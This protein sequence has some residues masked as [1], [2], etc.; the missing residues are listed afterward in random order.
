MK[1]MVAMCALVV[2]GGLVQAQLASSDSPPSGT[3]SSEQQP[4]FDLLPGV[5]ELSP[6]SAVPRDGTGMTSTARAGRLSRYRRF[7]GH[8]AL[9]SRHALHHRFARHHYGRHH[10]AAGRR[11]GQYVRHARFER[12]HHLAHYR[13]HRHPA[14]SRRSLAHRHRHRHHLV[15]SPYGPYGVP[16]AFYGPPGPYYGP[17]Y[18]PF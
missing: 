6:Q 12:G 15:L 1:W 9:S 10:L 13:Y 18:D 16:A 11:A 17:P 8:A 7:H 3:T 5:D 14:W 2:T 4:P